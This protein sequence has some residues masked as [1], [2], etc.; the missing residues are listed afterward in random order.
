[1]DEKQAAMHK[2]VA[3]IHQAGLQDVVPA[4]FGPW[5][6]DVAG[7]RADKVGIGTTRV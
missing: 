6:C 2:I 3:A 5:K 4:G 7:A 1:M